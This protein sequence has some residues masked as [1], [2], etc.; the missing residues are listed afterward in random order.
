MGKVSFSAVLNVWGKKVHLLY[1][2][3]IGMKQ[4]YGNKIFPVSMAMSLSGRLKSK[5]FFW[6]G[7]QG[8]ISNNSQ[9]V[10]NNYCCS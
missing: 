3:E 8:V 2:Q 4:I 10:K 1:R 9:F 7:R 6:A 5:P